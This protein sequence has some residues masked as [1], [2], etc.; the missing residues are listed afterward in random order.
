MRS[1]ERFNQ[2][3]DRSLIPLRGMDQS[4][5]PLGNARDRSFIPLGGGREQ[6]IPLSGID[7]S[8]VPVG[9][10]P[11]G[12]FIRVRGLG[13]ADDAADTSLFISFL[14]YGVVLAIGVFIGT[15]IK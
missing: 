7:N 3:V 6:F 4:F 10:A 14:K 15:K 12:G 11:P 1:Y 13:A 8:F 5:I 9:A 2:Q